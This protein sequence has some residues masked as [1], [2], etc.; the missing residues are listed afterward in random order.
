MPSELRQMDQVSWA[1]GRYSLQR[2]CQLDGLDRADITLLEQL[3]NTDT[4][5]HV[6]VPCSRRVWSIDG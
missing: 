5:S 3:V 1:C 6:N 2:L 4:R